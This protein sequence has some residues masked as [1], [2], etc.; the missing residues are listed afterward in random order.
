MSQEE[1]RRTRRANR[2]SRGLRRRQQPNPTGLQGPI[3]Q[4]QP[5]SSF[6][7]PN[8][9]ATSKQSVTTGLP[10]QQ[11]TGIG[12]D[13]MGGVLAAKGI[14]D[15]YETGGKAR[16]GFGKIGD[17]G[18]RAWDWLGDAWSGSP[19]GE[20][21][22]GFQMPTFFGDTPAT[23]TTPMLAPQQ[24]PTDFSMVDGNIT[25]LGGELVGAD[26]TF[27]G[28]GTGEVFQGSEGMG[29]LGA[30][31]SSGSGLQG[32]GSLAKAMPYLNIGKA[33]IMGDDAIT[34]SSAGDAALRTG[35][36]YLTGGLSE[37]GYGLYR[38]LV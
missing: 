28:G 9:V 10:E 21:T 33:L 25:S 36:A 37:L 2:A 17:A 35:A 31:P 26:S 11:G 29:S 19:V 7:K 34:G 1:R 13:L 30:D 8:P 20:A 32:S 3:Q 27:A 4:G 15:M 24:L 38:M 22:S 23:Q 18:G 16:E 6:R 5:R 14:G 12:G